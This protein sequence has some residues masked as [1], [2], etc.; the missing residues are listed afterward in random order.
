MA[1]ASARPASSLQVHHRV[2]QKELHIS[3]K[4]GSHRQKMSVPFTWYCWWKESCTSWCSR[5]TSIYRVLHIPGGAGFLPSTVWVSHTRSPNSQLPHRQLGG[6]RPRLCCKLLPWAML[7]VV[8]KRRKHRGSC[9]SKIWSSQQHQQLPSPSRKFACG[10]FMMPCP[11]NMILPEWAPS[12]TEDLSSIWNHTS[13]FLSPLGVFTM[14]LT[15]RSCAK[16][17]KSHIAISLMLKRWTSQI[18]KS[19]KIHC[20]QLQSISPFNSQLWFVR[21]RP[22]PSM[23]FWHTS[24]HHGG[25]ET[26]G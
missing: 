24:S 17:D 10:T 22:C 25:V 23:R 8:L 20:F 7:A 12:C 21:L 2:A 6:R 5:Y 11:A 3:C 16:L 15:I 1:T 26:L 14:L 18:K 4:E 19:L 9:L 13:M